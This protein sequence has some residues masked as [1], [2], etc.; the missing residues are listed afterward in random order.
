MCDL[1]C[2]KYHR[3]LSAVN[4]FVRNTVNCCAGMMMN[5]NEK[6]IKMSPKMDLTC[7]LLRFPL[8][9]TRKMKDYHAD[10]MR[11]G[12]LSDFQLKEHVKCKPFPTSM[13]A[14]VIKL[15]TSVK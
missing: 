11:C 4:K 6:D 5:S 1:F 9:L 13:D 10:D 8:R 12:D 14:T 7:T 2:D 3:I 15:V